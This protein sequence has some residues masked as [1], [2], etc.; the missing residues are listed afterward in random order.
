MESALVFGGVAVSLLVQFIKNKLALS[1]TSTMGLVALLSLGGGVAFY[2]L[3]MFGLWEAV[4]QVLISAGAFYAFVVRN[5][6][7]K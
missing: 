1:T 4:L 6:V 5:V 7:A 2:F 3:Q